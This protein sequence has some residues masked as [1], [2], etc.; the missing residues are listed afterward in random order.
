MLYLY[1]NIQYMTLTKK[2][3]VHNAVKIYL[4]H[5]LANAAIVQQ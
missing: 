1:S 4:T 3:K 5:Y 2:A